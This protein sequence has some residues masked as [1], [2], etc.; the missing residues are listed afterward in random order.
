MLMTTM[1]PLPLM[2]EGVRIALHPR[3]EGYAGSTDGKVWTCRARGHADKFTEW[4]EL[5]Q[6]RR[7]K[8]RYMQVTF[9]INKKAKVRLVQHVILEVFVSDRPVGLE[10]CHRDGDRG[11]NNLTNIR[12]DTHQANV[13]EQIGHGTRMDGVLNH[14]AKLDDDKVIEAKKMRAAGSTY[15]ELASFF[16]VTRTAIRYACTGITWKHLTKGVL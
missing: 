2:P 6:A 7:K 11:N 3:Y 16:G 14:K 1:P 9:K 15:D 10:S 13:D 8:N 5:A 4:K 12:W